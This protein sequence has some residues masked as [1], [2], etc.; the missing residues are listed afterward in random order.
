V[1]G[2]CNLVYSLAP[3]IDAT[4][5]GATVSGL[6]IQVHP[7]NPARIGTSMS[8]TLTVVATPVQNVAGPTLLFQISVVDSCPSTQIQFSPVLSVMTHTATLA[9][10]TQNFALGTDSKSVFTGIPGLCGPIAY[11]IDPDLL[12]I[13]VSSLV[14]PGTITVQTNLKSDVGVY[15]FNLTAVLSNYLAVTAI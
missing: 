5:Y 13:S 12:F 2:I 11:S 7:T 3:T 6:Q 4:A 14:N 10:A 8:L 15:N 9:A 1:S